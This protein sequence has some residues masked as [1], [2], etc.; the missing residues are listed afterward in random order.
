MPGAREGKKGSSPDEEPVEEEQEE[1]SNL[2]IA[3]VGRDKQRKCTD[4]TAFQ[5]LGRCRHG[6]D[7]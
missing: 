2:A 7:I 1:N 6:K 5:E 3:I 4:P